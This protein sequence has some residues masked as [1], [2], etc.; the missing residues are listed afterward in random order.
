M[1][2]GRIERTLAQGQPSAEAL[3]TLQRL[4]EDEDRHPALI[5]S[6][7]GERAI[8]D[9]FFEALQAGNARFA[10]IAGGKPPR[11]FERWAQE[12]ILALLTGSLK[13]ER[14]A[15]LKN[16]TQPVEIAK[17]PVEQQ[18][19]R[20]KQ[21]GIPTRADILARLMF[22]AINGIS[23]A[24]QKT[25]GRLRCALA[26]VAVERYRRQHGRW[27]ESLTELVPAQLSQLPLDP[28]D[29]QPIR[30]RRLTDGVVIY[31]LGPDLQDNGGKL[32]RQN[33]GATGTDLGLQLWDVDKRRAPSSFP[34]GKASR[35]AQEE[36]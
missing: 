18:A 4:L 24:L 5:V 33:P 12:V 7:R 19:A 3:A 22:P 25:Q 34:K 23:T 17:L 1:A 9:R 11:R 29:G 15:Y 27:P 21:R 30:Y 20:F 26:A 8:S 14:A 16:Q 6:L 32:D 28:F 31:C 13:K 35:P 2:L 36:K 10:T